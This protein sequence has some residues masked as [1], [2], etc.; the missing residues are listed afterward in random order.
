MVRLKN[1][2]IS[3]H[4]GFGLKWFVSHSSTRLN[5]SWVVAHLELAWRLK[6]IKKTFFFFFLTSF[7]LTYFKF[8]W[9]SPSHMQTDFFFNPFILLD[10]SFLFFISR[11]HLNFSPS[12]LLFQSIKVFVFLFFSSSDSPVG[13]HLDLSPLANHDSGWCTINFQNFIFSGKN[14]N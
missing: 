13:L 3:N 8:L 7:S 2:S 10:L 5:L 11:F 9:L 12:Y 1:E 14:S 4:I 6:K